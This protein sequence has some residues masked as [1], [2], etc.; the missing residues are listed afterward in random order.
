MKLYWHCK[1]ILL[2]IIFYSYPYML[3]PVVDDGSYRGGSIKGIKN[4][5]DH[6]ICGDR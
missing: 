6:S 2:I 5:T 1:S 4:W 3:A